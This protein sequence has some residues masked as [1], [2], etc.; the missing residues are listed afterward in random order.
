MRFRR[1]LIRA[2]LIVMCALMVLDAS[3]AAAAPTG[4]T[5]T[6][7]V[8]VYAYFY[9]WYDHGSWR[10][11]KA[12][13]PLVGTYSS[14]DPH[15]LRDQIEE[16][17]AAGIDGFLT[18]W[19]STPQL[20]R[21][22][23]LLLRVA[24]E[25]DFQV[26]VVYEA[27]DFARE[28]L[29][30][31]K[32]RSDLSFLMQ[33]WGPALNA[34]DFGKPLIA[35]TGTDQYS[36]SDIAS[37]RAMLAGRAFLLATSKDSEQYQRVAAEVDGEAYYWSS[38][39]PRASFTLRRLKDLAT[40]V[41]AH[42]GIWVAPAAPGFDGRTLGHLRVVDRAGS[43]TLTN[44]LTNAFAS[45][46]DAVGVISW[47]EWSEN[48]YIEPGQ[49]YGRQEFNALRKFLAAR[50]NDVGYSRVVHR[51]TARPGPWSGLRAAGLLT[52]LC[53]V[54]VGALILFGGRRCRWGRP[55]SRPAGRKVNRTKTLVG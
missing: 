3:P 18:S 33:R 17:K 46:P 38:A 36:L 48:T 5:S 15:I 53:L 35:W 55:T 34:T 30:A 45:S 47:N 23:D 25:L 50:G 19:K 9:Q 11:A 4:P 40:A 26:G 8:P 49:R 1:W 21:R 39:N 16:A 6:H 54:G 24:S 44:S 7:H 27:L 41:H 28:P 32:V 29:P 14:D 31:A 13:Y 22:L 20:N 12:D 43:A 42:D 37:V 10:R 51:V 2:V 52:L